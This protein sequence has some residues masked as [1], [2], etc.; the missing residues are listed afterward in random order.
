LVGKLK[1][2]PLIKGIVQKIK[3]LKVFD[4]TNIRGNKTKK[5]G[6]NLGS[7]L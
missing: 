1:G 5:K 7:D 4:G 3:N 2:D 6:H